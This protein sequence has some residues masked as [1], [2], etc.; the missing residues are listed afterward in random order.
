MV[1]RGGTRGNGKALAYYLTAKGENDTI[2]ILDIDG[3]KGADRNDLVYHL[4][5]WSLMSELTKSDKG[6]YHAVINPAYGDDK[7]MTP[8]DWNRAADILAKEAG[9]G[10]Q[11]RAIILHEKNDR[12]HAHVVYERYDHSRGIMLS[13]SFNRLAQDRARLMMEKEFEHQITPDRNNHRADVKRDI[14]DIWHSVSTGE[15][16]VNACEKKGYAITRTSQRRSFSVVDENGISYDLPRQIEG[17]KTKAVANKL[18]EL[19]LK[20][21]REV[22]REIRI[23]QSEK[24]FDFIQENAL[25]KIADFKEQIL[26]DAQ[27][28]TELQSQKRRRFEELQRQFAKTREQLQNK[29]KEF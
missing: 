4:T 24:S 3:R 5:S 25:N 6:L 21:S 19:S 18:K 23:K 29:N 10:G 11:R 2:E 9:Y 15:E 22:I 14:S 16:F 26:A 8:E 17:I 13:D 27:S 20:N 7:K 1:I 28:E 12:I